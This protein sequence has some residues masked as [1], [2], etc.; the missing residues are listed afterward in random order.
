MRGSSFGSRLAGRLGVCVDMLHAPLAEES[1]AR[2][3]AA[4][5]PRERL[6][7]GRVAVR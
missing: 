7:A 4:P 5:W 6:Y 3:E 2:Q 1:L